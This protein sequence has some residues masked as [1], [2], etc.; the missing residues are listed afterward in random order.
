MLTDLQK[1][2]IVD[3]YSLGTTIKELVSIY[4]T[5]ISNIRSLL[6]RRGVKIRENRHR[7]Y[8]FN[9]NFFDVIDNEEKAYWLGFIFG[10]GG[11][12]K[13]S[14]RLEL[15]NKDL[16]HVYKFINTINLNTPIIKT[17]KNCVL[18]T[19]NSKKM[20]TGLSKYG[21]IQNKTY[22]TNSIPLNL[23]SKQLQKHF[24]RGIFDADGWIVEHKRKY[25]KS[26]FE[27]GF[28]SYHIN[29][30]HQIQNWIK[31]NNVINIS[32]GY[33][34]ERIKGNQK[35]CQFIIG[36]NNNFQK[37]TDLIYSNSNVFLERKKNKISQFMQIIH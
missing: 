11:I 27:Y 28:S 3:K 10:D 8:N 26:Q 14:L 29:I 1:I 20:I 30:L 31:E 25:N 22:L 2:E 13:Y 36:G 7:K 21:I 35:V 34:K 4:G 17:N 15:S 18:I 19:A 16:D 6:I 37:I 32:N 9:E 23:I 33:I 12:S 24:I 5:T